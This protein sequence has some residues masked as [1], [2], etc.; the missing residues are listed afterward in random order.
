M[1]LE[2]NE[3]V[4]GQLMGELQAWDRARTVHHCRTIA[5][6]LEHV[7][8]GPLDIMIADLHLP[9]GSGVD[10]IRAA[11]LHRPEAIII[12]TSALNEGPVVLNAIRAGAAGY[13]DKADPTIDVL[14]AI[15]QAM[16]GKAPMSG[17]IARLII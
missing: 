11:R 5:E 14:S 16:S 17:T 15:D 13:V 4:A 9:D 3:A 2:D 6:G 7:A 1:L 12:V 8:A 10:V